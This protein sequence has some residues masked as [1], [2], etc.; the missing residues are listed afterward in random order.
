MADI[1]RN[2]AEQRTGMAS[3]ESWKKAYMQ[4]HENLVTLVSPRW[5]IGDFII[6][7]V[8]KM[9]G[10]TPSVPG[11]GLGFRASFA[12]M[13]RIYMKALQIDLIDIGVQLRFDQTRQNTVNWDATR[14]RLNDM[15]SKL[16]MYIQAVRDYEYMTDATQKRYDMFI[17]SSE[18]YQDGV[19][20][21]ASIVKAEK[22]IKDF[23][24]I[25]Q[26]HPL[27]TGPWEKDPQDGEPVPIGGTRNAGVQSLLR[28]ALIVRI[29][30]ALLG[31]AFLVGPIW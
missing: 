10:K 17:A 2:A 16:K 18:R 29:G 25:E 24:E 19:H 13:Q 5:A 3:C 26:K 21:V 8:Y 1:A 27:P 12:E 7:L 23:K 28:R 9:Y 31:S 11:R 6:R 14:G 15:E 20:L 4:H 30:L 22:R